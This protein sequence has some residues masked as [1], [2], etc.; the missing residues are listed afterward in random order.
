MREV[1]AVCPGSCGELLQG[2]VGDSQK[3]VSY[4]IDRF[5][6][7]SVRTGEPSE[8]PNPKVSEAVKKTVQYLGI[9]EEQLKHMTIFVQSDLPI[10][11]GMASSTADIAAACQA[12]AAYF[13]KQLSR[14]EILA[15]C[16]AIERTDSILFPSLTL[17]EQKAGSLQEISGWC[18]DFYVVVLEPEE[19]LETEAFHSQKTEALFFQQRER[20]CEVYRLYTE[21]IQERNIQKLG[22]AALQ[23][24]L[25]NQEILPKPFFSE[26]VELSR[27]YRLLGVNVA[28]SGS[29]IGL[30]ID[31]QEQ[32]PEVL[33][34]VQTAPLRKWY[35]KVNV[36]QS[37]YQGVQ[38]A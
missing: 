20:F 24:A 26:V 17:F 28:H 12:V 37:C 27:T 3:L 30:M 10:A 8:K 6:R 5:S 23:S 33:K 18:P 36:H 7:V 14:D 31:Q 2:W 35:T 21:A 38:L 16:L 32:I 34:A 22:T 29:V 15:I 13:G 9:S 4:G 19:T 11:K 25:L 1:T